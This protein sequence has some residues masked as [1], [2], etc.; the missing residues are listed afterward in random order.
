MIFVFLISL[1]DGGWSSWG[2]FTSCDKPCDKLRN[3][4][5]TRKCNNPIPEFGGKPC[6]GNRTEKLPCN[7]KG[8]NSKLIR[9][10]SAKFYKF[11]RI[12]K[13]FNPPLTKVHI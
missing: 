10:A 12:A 8:C 4:E 6:I 3:R 2:N 5:R 7:A 9:K 1:E 13:V 11:K